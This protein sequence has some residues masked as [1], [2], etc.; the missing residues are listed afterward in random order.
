MT[1]K[2]NKILG[3]KSETNFTFLFGKIW[4]QNVD[5]AQKLKA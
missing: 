4:L 5:E 1:S 3:K 2:N